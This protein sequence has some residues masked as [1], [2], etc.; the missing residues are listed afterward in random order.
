MLWTGDHLSECNIKMEHRLCFYRKVI[1]SK[2]Y[3]TEALSGS[4]GISW[5][6][7][8]V[9]AL[10]FVAVSTLSSTGRCDICEA[11]VLA[12]ARDVSIATSR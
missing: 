12:N 10:S 4:G 7:G 5:L 9:M 1:D 2:K 6:V 11:T 8:G 3:T